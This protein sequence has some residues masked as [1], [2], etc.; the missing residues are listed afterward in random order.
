[1]LQRFGYSPGVTLNG[2][3]LPK[4]GSIPNMV[5]RDTHSIFANM[6]FNY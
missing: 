3:L 2:Q 1:V 5:Q 4:T 6:E